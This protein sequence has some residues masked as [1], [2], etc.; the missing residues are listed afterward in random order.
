LSGKKVWDTTIGLGEKYGSETLADVIMNTAT[1]RVFDLIREAPKDQLS[2]AGII[3]K[4]RIENPKEWNSALKNNQQWNYVGDMMYSK[5]LTNGEYLG[6]LKNRDKALALAREKN[7]KAKGI[8]V[9]DFDDTLAR[10]KSKVI[11]Y[12]PAFEPGTS[13]E[14]SMRLT[15]AEFAKRHAEL[16]R[17]GAS[18]D[19]SEFNK[20]LGGKK[21]PL[22]DLAVKRQGKFGPFLPPN[23]LLNSEK[24]NEAPILSNSA[25][26]LANSAGVNLILTSLLVPGSKAGA[27]TITLDLVLANV[28]SKSNTLIPLAFLFFSLA[29][30][31]ALSLFFKLPRYSPLVKSLLYIISPT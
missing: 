14:V 30:A 4:Q 6:S 28:S 16:E 26:L 15:P 20:V 11:V 24:S 27:Y 9:F 1:R 23:T 17:M 10:T 12:A 22:F 25:C 3:A 29:N 13:R 31:K 8:S 19:F 18:F 2:T 5:D 7:K 21:G